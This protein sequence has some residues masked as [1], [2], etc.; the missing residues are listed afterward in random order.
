[1]SG[2]AKGVGK[3][4]KKAAKVVKK[5]APIALGAA[6]V[7]FTAG[8]ALGFAPT[9]GA[10][11]GSLVGSSVLGNTTLASVVTGAITQAGYGAAIGGLTAAAT[12]GSI[13]KG[14]QTGALTP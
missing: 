7:Y 10:A 14:M 2:V 4:F 12:G 8:A 9:L 5:V 11:A 3:V 6:A 13:S 1:M